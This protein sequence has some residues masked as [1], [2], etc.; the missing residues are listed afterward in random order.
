MTVLPLTSKGVLQLI[1]IRAGTV[2]P[3]WLTF[4]QCFGILKCSQKR[5]EPLSLSQVL[6]SSNE[7][8]W[9]S[10][11]WR[12]NLP[13]DAIPVL[14]APEC[15]TLMDGF[16]SQSI[17]DQN[18]NK[19]T[20]KQTNKQNPLFW[21][22]GWGTEAQSSLNSFLIESLAGI[23]LEPMILYATHLCQRASF[24]LLA[25]FK[26]GTERELKKNTCKGIF[27]LTTETGQLDS[28]NAIFK[29]VCS[30]A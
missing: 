16:Y 13:M 18:P 25:F 23:R 30:S 12:K 21:S 4:P 10:L 3:R 7:H 1:L 5:R 22:C 19:Q 11:R 20:K 27:S 14:A 26:R 9:D 28:N 6:E 2:S 29:C 15:L 24:L 17:P 8:I